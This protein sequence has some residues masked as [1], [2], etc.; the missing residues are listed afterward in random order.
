MTT[1]TSQQLTL[2]Q[3]KRMDI[4]AAAREEFLEAGFRETSMDRVAERANVSKRTVYNHFPSKEELFKAIAGQFIAELKQAIKVDYD[5]ARPLDEQLE[6]IARREVELVTSADHVAI[7]R[8]FL[9]ELGNFP[10]LAEEA[11]ADVGGGHDPVAAWIEAAAKDGKLKVASSE[12]A[13][14]QFVS[15][16]K[17]ALFWPLM[18]G[19]SRQ[20][21]K[22]EQE[23][24]IQGAVQ[25]ML[26]HYAP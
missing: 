16:L 9:A 8:V 17:G 3:R 23:A 26:D 18:M 15:L 10:G 11:L 1:D 14:N 2:T 7:F 6:E 12:L 4:L 22:A 13:A 5:P 20:A 21:S 25:M 19:M 24:V